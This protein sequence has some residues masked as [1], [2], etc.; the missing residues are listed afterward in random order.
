M[1]TVLEDLIRNTS[2]PT[3]ILEARDFLQHIHRLVFR[4]RSSMQALECH[5]VEM[6]MSHEMKL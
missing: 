2:H 6:G 4:R 3:I 1:T 5:S